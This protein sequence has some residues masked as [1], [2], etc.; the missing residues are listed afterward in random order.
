MAT[1]K[2]K[3]K[4]PEALK[5]HQFKKGHKPVPKGQGKPKKK[6]SEKSPEEQAKARAFFAKKKSEKAP[7][8]KPVAKKTRKATKVKPLL[9]S[10]K[11]KSAKKVDKGTTKTLRSMNAM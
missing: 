6:L 3:R 7:T 1:E 4:L 2:P 9:K 10:R 11:P 8:S 5:K